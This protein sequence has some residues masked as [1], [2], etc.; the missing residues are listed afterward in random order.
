MYYRKIVIGYNLDTVK[1]YIYQIVG[2]LSVNI[3][4]K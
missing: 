2:T 4:Y 1:H 3:D